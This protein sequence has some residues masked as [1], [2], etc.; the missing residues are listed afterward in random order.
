MQSS[1]IRRRPIV[2]GLLGFLYPGLGHVYLR[3]WIRAIAWFGL[4]MI[5]ATLVIPDS[6]ITAFQQNGI[7]G[8]VAA[9]RDLPMNVVLSLFVVRI[10]NV[11]DAY[12]TG[13]RQE[14]AT[15]QRAGTEAGTCPNCGGELDEDIDFCP[16]C[17]TELSEFGTEPELD[18]EDA[19]GGFSFR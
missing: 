14:R 5:T 17:T 2:A 3:A 7:D 19:S 13:L 12:L 1:L 18:E 6:A 11:I 10:L 8:L 16:W 15:E 9:S 4:A